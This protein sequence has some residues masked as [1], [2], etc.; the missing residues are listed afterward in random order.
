MGS[1]AGA[2]T[3]GASVPTVA[4]AAAESPEGAA[5]SA[6]AGALGEGVVVSGA[7]V[8]GAA[9]WAIAV[10]LNDTNPT[11]PA[12][13]NRFLEIFMSSFDLSRCEPKPNFVTAQ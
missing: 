12:Y 1:G 5:V 7:G 13:D 10:W 6:A 8:V 4:V 9:V 2:V 11:T 3:V